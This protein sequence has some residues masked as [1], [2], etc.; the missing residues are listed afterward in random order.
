MQTAPLDIAPEEAAAPSPRLPRK[1]KW[2]RRIMRTV[3]VILGVPLLLLLALQ[4]SYPQTFV[5]GFALDWL[6]KELAF[7]IEAKKIHFNAFASTLTLENVQ[8]RDRQGKTMI[9]VEQ[10]V[11]DFDYNT[12]LKNGDIYLKDVLL[13]RGA[14]N[15]I[16]DEKSKNLNIEEF[17]E[18]IEK[19][20]APKE[21]KK[22][23]APTIFQIRHAKLE[24]V[25]FSYHDNELPYKK[26]N[27]MDYAHFGLEHLE[28]D[29]RDLRIAA[30]TID[31]RI[32]GL[33][34][35]EQKTQLPIHDLTTHLF[36]TAKGMNF[37]D[38]YLAVG[39]SILRKEVKMSY[40]KPA[41]LS[42][43]VEKVNLE[44]DFDSTILATQDLQIFASELEAY[45][46]TWRITG[47][48]KGRVADF[49]MDDLQMG[50]GKGSTWRGYAAMK[51]LPA[52]ENTYM[53]LEFKEAKLISRDL[54]QYVNQ[55]DANEILEKLGEV[56]IFKGL[57]KGYISDF[58]AGGSFQT[59]LGE[60]QTQMRLALGRGRQVPYYKAKVSTPDLQ[61]GKLLGLTDL[62]N[63]AVEGEVEGTGFTPETAKLKLDTKVKFA[64]FN[65]YR[66]KNIEV[67][68]EISH[69]RF[70]GDCYAKDANLDFDLHGTVDFNPRKTE[71]KY[72]PGRFKLTA[73]LR[74]IDLQALN[75]M[76]EK[77]T[78]QGKIDMDLRGL[79]LD[80]LSGWAS[81]QDLD[82][83]YKGKNLHTKHFDLLS[84]KRPNGDR[85][86]IINS[87][88]VIIDTE[89]KFYFSDVM[90]DLPTLAYEYY[91]SLENRKSTLEKYYKNKKK[92]K[93]KN[94]NLRFDLIL[95]DIN[96]ILAFVDEKLHVGKGA[97][98]HGTFA[99]QRT[100]RLT[101][102]TE[103][104]I[105]SVFYGKNK[106][107]DIH[108]DLTSSKLAYDS[109]VLA[110]LQLQS[111]RQVLG[112]MDFD[113]TSIDASWGRE[114]IDFESKIH[115][116]NSS[117]RAKL[118][119]MMKLQDDT[120]LINFTNTDLQIYNDHWSFDKNNEINI[121][122]YALVFKDIVLR[123]Q[124]NMTSQINVRGII[125]DS[126]PTPLALDLKQIDLGSFAQVF[127]TDLN[128]TLNGN[129]ILAN[130]TKKPDIKGEMNIENLMY[131]KMLI[132]DVDGVVKWID[133]QEKLDI[134]LTGFRKNR[135]I[136][137]LMGGYYPNKAQDALDL[138]MK[139]NRTDLEILEPFADEFIS[140]VGGN[141]QGKVYIKGNPNKPILH[142]RVRINNGRFKFNILGTQYD[143][144]GEIFIEENEIF[145]S[146]IDLYD[147]RTNPATVSF[148]LKHK[149]FENF[150]TDV[151]ARFYHE[152]QVMNTPATPNCMYYGTAYASGD[153]RIRGAIDN[154]TMLVN[155]K[156]QKGTKIYLPIDGYQ[157]VGAK[158]Y[159]RFV[160]NNSKKDSVKVRKVNLGGLKMK[161]NLDVTPNADFEI[162]IDS[163]TGDMIT[164]KG[165]GNINMEINQVGDMS[166][167][168][169]Y[170][171]QQ[172]KYNFTFANLVNKSFEITPNSSIQFNGDVFQSQLDVKAVYEKSVPFLPLIDFTKLPERERNN[173]ELK[174]PYPVKATLAMRGSLFKP[175]I[176]L[177]LDLSA[178]DRIVN[179]NLQTAV[180]QLKSQVAN[181]EQER[182]RQVF[183]ILLFGQLSRPNDFTVTGT[184][185][186]SSLSEMLANQFSSWISQ[187]DENLD[188]NFNVADFT[189]RGS[190]Q[191]RVSYNFLDGRLR[192]TREGGFTNTQNQTDLSSAI[193]DWTLEYM[194]NSS[195][196][197]RL[198][199]YRRNNTG[200][201]GAGNGTSNLNAAGVATVGFSVMYTDGFNRLAD[202][203]ARGRANNP[204]ANGLRV[205]TE[206]TEVSL[207]IN[208]EMPTLN[209]Q[210][211]EAQTPS[212]EDL[213]PLKRRTDTLSTMHRNLPAPKENKSDTP[214]HLPAKTP[215]TNAEEEEEIPDR[216]KT[217]DKP[218]Q[219][220]AL[221]TLPAFYYES[222]P[223]GECPLPH[224]FGVK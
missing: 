77:T 80:S 85:Q 222:K 207:N 117:N 111:S 154:L 193:G 101:I 131:K 119:G 65:Q 142:G 46:D 160:T 35:I 75:F 209:V 104:P 106:L 67:K 20:T 33:K 125:S 130:L 97:I 186:L 165:K 48:L 11:V 90:Q 219:H 1:G 173:A 216:Y 196:K 39:K 8:I 40:E 223:V 144:E 69:Q 115:Q 217:P 58:E 208:E 100:S 81:M 145:A 159:I 16:I 79:H 47:K 136:L 198:K 6:S 62:Q 30:D 29:L 205:D 112:G 116:A 134:D 148:K 94:Y 182:N 149:N 23:S 212:E 113:S 190:Y 83:V 138:E 44:V 66:Y 218:K 51:G 127:K 36:M 161:F 27:G 103:K 92:Q 110:A 152:F 52:I 55:D 150:N 158:D 169:R 3:G 114:G 17:I 206:A 221:V 214:K 88:Y 76:P 99:Q 170:D 210:K 105:D 61:I 167:K 171:I 60:F 120:T 183:S 197:A 189:N 174:R 175:E 2:R 50:W 63:V 155:A 194:L 220:K 203:F 98:L 70:E 146:K 91:L 224:R 26:G 31:V 74:H 18:R 93:E 191:L 168:G 176:K 172:G 180:L 184:G 96:P 132:G 123:N 71:E 213:F 10:L 73:D 82:M 157:E 4:F 5:A 140:K 57:Y 32:K 156:A 38:L 121:N 187:V 9:A 13:K 118:M 135:Y 24:D 15:L 151:D 86:F 181:D 192:L 164:A 43:F 195:G 147:E 25:F 177:G 215:S 53:N 108:V 153:A 200:M 202:L 133:D 163:R 126:L 178:G 59:A 45:K 95:N 122:P 56:A 188:I 107:Y 166:L 162:I 12:V 84:E 211:K 19:L 199:T 7:P 54:I 41:D 141:L 179:P 14:I 109:E 139:F 124:R 102:D 89:G 204:N 72:P 128:G 28:G 21:P 22:N 201:V 37:R 68:G 129:F 143:A 49:V 87:D 137:S 42:K 78:L 185:G 64:D 34:A